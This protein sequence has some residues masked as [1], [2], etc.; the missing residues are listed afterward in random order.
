MT[1][2]ACLR[3]YA[4]ALLAITLSA[5]GGGTH[6]VCPNPG[7]ASDGHG[8]VLLAG[9]EG[10]LSV[11]Q[12]GVQ[13]LQLKRPSATVYGSEGT[14][15]GF[16]PNG[17]IY[18]ALSDNEH[19]NLVRI[20]NLRSGATA[21]LGNNDEVAEYVNATADKHNLYTV[22]QL[23]PEIRSMPLDSR[24]SGARVFIGGSNTKLKD[25]GH[26][27]FDPSGELC[28]TDHDTPE[29]ACF[30]TSQ[31]GNVHPTRFLNLAPHVT[32]ID[33]LAFDSQGN[34]VVTGT[35]NGHDGI[36]AFDAKASDGTNPLWTIGGDR[37]G[38][39]TPYIR[40]SRFAKQD[41]RA[42]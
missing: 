20:V 5:C 31:R 2:L 26:I 29:I 14:R 6:W 3:M 38:L 13:T 4:P 9:D 35:I 28:V 21:L 19:P 30:K 24:G 34:Y 40:S 12:N 32:T 16:A 36:A 7:L 11:T 41:L 27:A 23:A 37:S 17:N 18:V 1:P 33:A 42:Q 25:P 39:T 15:F 8:T 22:Q 10:F